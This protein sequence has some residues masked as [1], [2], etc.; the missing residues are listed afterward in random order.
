MGPT[1]RWTYIWN[2]MGALQWRYNQHDGVSNHQPHNCLLNHLLKRRS[3]KKHQS[4]ASLAF[5]RGIH[6][7]PVNSPTQK[8]SNEEN[9]SIWWRHHGCIIIILALLISSR[10]LTYVS[11]YIEYLSINVNYIILYFL[12]S[13]HRL[14]LNTSMKQIL[15]KWAGKTRIDKKYATTEIVRNIIIAVYVI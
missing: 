13:F 3:K 11:M 2:V 8:A 6:R 14:R 4:S 15:S 1:P 9:V 10:H 5:V 12:I 7:W